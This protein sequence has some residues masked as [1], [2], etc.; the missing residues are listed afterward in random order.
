MMFQMCQRQPPPAWTCSPAGQL[1]SQKPFPESWVFLGVR[2][3]P[4]VP[5]SCLGLLDQL[6]TSLLT[7]F[8]SLFL[9][10][11]ICVWYLWY[12][13]VTFNKIPKYLSIFILQGV[14]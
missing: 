8:A 7:L 14:G 4:R 11:E 9:L 6:S 10:Q 1:L 2:A 5:L 12:Y 3:P 13:G